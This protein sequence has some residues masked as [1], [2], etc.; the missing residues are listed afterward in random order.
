MIIFFYSFDMPFVIVMIRCKKSDV[1]YY[2]NKFDIVFFLSLY[3]SKG[4][5]IDSIHKNWWGNYQLLEDHH[6]YIQW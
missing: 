1:R 6:S 4:D 2:V 3:H 5:L